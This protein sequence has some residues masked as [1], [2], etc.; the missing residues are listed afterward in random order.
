MA[1]NIQISPETEHKIFSAMESF[2]SAAG[3][4]S[5]LDDCECIFEKTAN[6]H[7]FTISVPT[8]AYDALSR[9]IFDVFSAAAKPFYKDG[10]ISGFA[11]LQGPS[12]VFRIIASGKNTADFGNAIVGLIEGAKEKIL[13]TPDTPSLET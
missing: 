1:D 8:S 13:E 5:N 4:I 9:K 12:A 10:R 6:G 7:S 2:L 3:G 11:A